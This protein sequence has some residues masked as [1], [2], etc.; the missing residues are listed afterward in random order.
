M[1][2]P[3]SSSVSALAYWL[4]M[5]HGV[6]SGGAQNWDQCV[7]KSRDEIQLENSFSE[8]ANEYASDKNAVDQSD[9]D[10]VADAPPNLI[11]L[12]FEEQ[13]QKT[14][15]VD[16]SS[17]AFEQHA[18]RHVAN[19]R[20]NKDVAALLFLY[21]DSNKRI[22][23]AWKRRKARGT[24]EKRPATAQELE[25]SVHLA[26]TLRETLRT[27]LVESLSI[28]VDSNQSNAPTS[29]DPNSSVSN[30]FV[31]A[32]FAALAAAR[33]LYREASSALSTATRDAVTAKNASEYALA[34][35]ANAS[36]VYMQVQQGNDPM[37]LDGV[38]MSV[39]GTVVDLERDRAQRLARLRSEVIAT[40]ERIATTA[41]LAESKFQDAANLK[42]FETENGNML[43]KAVKAVKLMLGAGDDANDDD[44]F[45]EEPIRYEAVAAAAAPAN[46][47]DQTTIAV[48][49]ADMLLKAR[50]NS[51]RVLATPEKKR[52]K[53]K[54]TRN[55]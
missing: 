43:V 26:K 9:I 18:K 13:I 5:E 53:G 51:V 29:N 7:A 8:K 27:A 25:Q 24:Y 12:P 22:A 21:Q 42:V 33:A 37:N 39:D 45:G 14:Q 46:Q 55:A 23:E 41:H 1:G 44:D 4:W 50:E 35:H 34:A 31:N 6:V 19:L 30:D 32:T 16:V 47:I 52:G 38:E 28:L 20:Q 48:A 11:G 40:R 36:A 15:T 17:T 3:N 10:T 49:E 54:V 2:N